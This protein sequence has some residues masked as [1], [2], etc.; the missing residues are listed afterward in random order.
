MSNPAFAHAPKASRCPS[1]R[2]SAQFLTN[3]L[4][5]KALWL[6][7][8]YKWNATDL[9]QELGECNRLFQRHRSGRILI[10]FPCRYVRAGGLQSSP[11]LRSLLIH[12]P[13]WVPQGQCPSPFRQRFSPGTFIVLFTNG[14]RRHKTEQPP[15]G[16]RQR[17]RRAGSDCEHVIHIRLYSVCGL[18]RFSWHGR[19]PRG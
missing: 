9:Y 18:A 12:R 3:S 16:L 1:Y 15:V 19:E 10:F 14:S 8:F 2:K 11:P 13:V 6:P 7:A 17:G 4:E 5:G